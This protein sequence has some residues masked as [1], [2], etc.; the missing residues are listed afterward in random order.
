[1]SDSDNDSDI[2]I[3]QRQFNSLPWVEKYRPDTLEQLK[4]HDEIKQ[5][6]Q[7]FIQNRC[8]PHLLFYGSPGTGKT[9]CIMA[10][11][12]Q[13]YGKYMPF[14]VMELNASDD[15]G[16]ETVRSKI[17]Q[18]VMTQG[19]FFGNNQLK[20]MFKLVILDETDAMTN[21]AQ[22]NL[23]KIIEDYTYNTRF[24][25]ICNYIQ[26]INPALKSRCTRFR[27]SLLG[28][29]QIKE[30]LVEIS[31]TEKIIINDSGLNTII[32][33]SRG[34]LRKAI[35]ML[36]SISMVYPNIKEKNVNICIGYP[37]KSHIRTILDYLQNES[38]KDTYK[39]IIQLK[40]D[41]GLS[42][43]DIMQELHDALLNHLLE[44]NANNFEITL[45]KN[46][47]LKILD[48]MR[49][50]EYNHFASTNENVQI[51]ALISTFKYI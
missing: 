21:D 10:V 44:E 16:I 31:E 46:N 41:H 34:D 15:R 51:S 20:D 27:F 9:S 43:N 3:K 18:F 45:E 40:T 1:M 14:M 4:S 24:C 42:L 50:I 6:L 39:I 23:R 37:R 7:T 13:L 33:L 11:A 32:K 49:I 30:K 38:F 12:K 35:N 28:I 19:I 5:T 29:N 48:Q 36:Q 47:I 17:K 22:A 2:E 26:N 8:L 25:L